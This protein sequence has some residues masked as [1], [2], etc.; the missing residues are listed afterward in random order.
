[1]ISGM[2]VTMYRSAKLH[3]GKKIH[4]NYGIKDKYTDLAVIFT[5]KMLLDLNHESIDDVDEFRRISRGIEAIAHYL[6][7]K[8]VPE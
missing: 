1:M 7:F 3:K 5:R 4:S 2:T 8:G 6:D